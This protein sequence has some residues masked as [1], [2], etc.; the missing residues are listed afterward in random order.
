MQKVTYIRTAVPDDFERIV[1][2]ENA[3]FTKKIA[4]NRRQLRYLLFKANS[5][6]LVET[7]NTI[8]HGF[9]IVLYRKGTSV[10]GIETINVDPAYRNHGVGRR[11][12]ATAENDVRDKGMKKIRLEV[13]TTNHSA[14]KLYKNAGFTAISLLKNY[15]LFNHSGSRDAIRMIKKIS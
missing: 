13:A 3:C 6:V 4:Y 15:Y 5:T 12:L 11:L 2:I 10:A 7:H 14:I 9:I 8:I 1:A